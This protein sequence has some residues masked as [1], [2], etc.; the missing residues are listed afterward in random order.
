CWDG[1][2]K[3]SPAWLLVGVPA[4]GLLLYDDPYF[5]FL[6]IVP[7]VGL[8]AVSALIRRFDRRAAVLAAVLAAGALAYRAF[9][10]LFRSVGIEPAKSSTS[11]ASLD[12]IRHHFRLLVH[13]GLRLFEA[14]LI[15]NPL[16]LTRPR[17]LLN[18]A[19]LLLALLGPVALWRRRVGLRDQPWQWFFVLHPLLVAAVF[20]FSNQVHDLD[21]ARYLVLIPFVLVLVIALGLDGLRRERLRT[22]ALLLVGVTTA[23]NL[24]VT[25]DYFF[26]EPREG[27]RVNEVIV[28]AAE[29]T[30]ANKGYAGYW[31]S[32]INTYLS[33]DRVD[34]IQ[35][36]CKEAK[37]AP[38]LW[39]LDTGI[40]TKPAT[41]TFFVWEEGDP[42]SGCVYE[43][44]MRQFG[45]P[46]AV[47]RVRDDT[48]LLVYE[49][50]LIERM[51]PPSSELP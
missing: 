18:L 35:I 17:L 36:V 4:V 42:R 39:L 46:A 40:L 2:L 43:E 20:V 38:Y 21:S 13:G 37:A 14:D 1:E 45:E 3:P 28:E 33:D 32:N 49:Y 47:V 9:E 50:D 29:T 44:L 12:G 5:L 31:S 24:F 22:G 6:W 25:V 48:A 19:V 34:F 51:G 41:R 30:G 8:L 16:S 27:N 11:L 10:V 23:T 7:L 15:S 26:N